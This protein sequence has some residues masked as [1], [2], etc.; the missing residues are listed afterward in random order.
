MP[1]NN[2][3]SLKGEVHD[4]LAELAHKARAAYSVM[5]EATNAQ[6][7]MAL[8]QAALSLRARKDHILTLNARD[9]AFGK[10]KGL[11]A[12]QLDRLTLDEKRIEA[13]AAG[14]ETIA[15]VPDPVNKVLE[16][17]SRP[18]GL[19]LQR[20]SIPLGVIGIIYESRPNVTADAAGLCIKSGN[21]AILRCGSE[22]LYSSLAIMESIHTGLSAAGLPVDAIQLVPT[23]D[24]LAVS[25]MLGLSGLIDVIVPRGGKSL[26]ARVAEESRIPTLLHL[27]GN[28][29]TYIHE[30]ADLNM[31]KEVLL[32]A[33]MR[34]VGICGA[35][36]SLLI[37]RNSAEDFL[38][39]LAEALLAR[40]CEIRGDEDAR[41][42]HAS[43]T[44]ATDEDWETEYLAPI[45]SV[46]LVDGLED[47]IAHINRHGSH[48]TDAIITADTSTARQFLRQVDSAIVMH[49]TSTQFADGGEFG[50]G[51]EIG[52]S[53]GRLHARGPVGAEQLTTY[54]YVV[55][56]TGQTRP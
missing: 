31:A 9:L 42:Q 11:D 23:R 12:A 25:A 29:H 52:I 33:K 5:A 7:D 45:I 1:Q 4:Q 37:D 40:G 21:A 18:N 19:V 24:R 36:E 8:A 14:L 44:P 10:E 47:A 56:G 41:K 55:H 50:F 34:R 54:K 35:T 17:W 2:I 20:V 51:A 30:K 28:C 27:E 38:P 49:N 3:V 13:M 43:I 46:K 16:E 15:T 6:K 26:N 32:N 39:A 53:T 22:C 48:H